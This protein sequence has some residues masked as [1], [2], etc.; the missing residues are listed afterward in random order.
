MLPLVGGDRREAIFLSEDDRN[1]LL[2]IL[3]E[4]V[5]NFNWIIHAYCL[6]DIHYYLLIETLD[7]NLSKGMQQLRVGFIS[8]F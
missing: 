1:P 5:Q 4:V 3:S 2:Y 6:M 8:A 7:G